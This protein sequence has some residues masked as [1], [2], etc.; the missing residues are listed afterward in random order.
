M[1]CL[2]D[3]RD[4]KSIFMGARERERK[5]ILKPQHKKAN[6]TK[7]HHKLYLFISILNNLTAYTMPFYSYHNNNS[8][9]E[10]HFSMG[11]ARN[12][13]E[14]LCMSSKKN[15]YTFPKKNVVISNAVGV[16][17]M[18]IHKFL[19]LFFQLH[20]LPGEYFERTAKRKKVNIF[21][22]PTYGK[23]QRTKIYSPPTP[24]NHSCELE[25]NGRE[26]QF[27]ETSGKFN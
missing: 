27:L 11:G 3:P 23:S 9:S 21:N 18:F 4:K 16:L 6:A 5:E 12:M 24:T 2:N 10:I 17:S 8:N 14:N 1:S 25:H 15:L 22:S 26:C 20:F 13:R 7:Q 19:S